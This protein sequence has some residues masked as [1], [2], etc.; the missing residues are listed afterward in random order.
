M[1]GAVPGTSQFDGIVLVERAPRG[2][3]LV[4]NVFGLRA[5]LGCARGAGL[6]SLRAPA[7][8]RDGVVRG[9]RT[10]GEKWVQT[11]AIV[12]SVGGGR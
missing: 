9:L 2:R 12:L 3:I 1:P 8:L 6:S 4:Y 7:E 10:W 11:T 5:A